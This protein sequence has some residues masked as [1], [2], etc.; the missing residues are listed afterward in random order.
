MLLRKSLWQVVLALAV[1][2]V[3]RQR[4]YFEFHSN[5]GRFLIECASKKGVVADSNATIGLQGAPLMDDRPTE[6]Y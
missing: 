3:R 4:D 1:D 2:V 5:S 6:R